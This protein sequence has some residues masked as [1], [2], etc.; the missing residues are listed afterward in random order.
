MSPAEMKFE[1]W[2]A[3][4]IHLLKALPN[5]DGAF[6]TMSISFSL[7]E[8]YIKS[9]LVRSGKT[10]NPSA[11]LKRASE[12]TRVDEEC[13]DKF[14]GMYRVGIQHFLQPKVFE[15]KGVKYGWSINSD[16]PAL[17]YFMIDTDTEKLIAFDPWKWADWVVDLYRADPNILEIMESHALGDIYDY[18]LGKGGELSECIMALFLCQYDKEKEG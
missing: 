8:R 16:Y 7:F 13:F 9:D 5:G 18:G 14:W 6:A 3:A 11:F 2:F 1:R 10:A 17:P 4:P 12:I 15:S